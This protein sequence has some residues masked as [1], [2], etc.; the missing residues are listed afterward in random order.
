V[1]RGGGGVESSNGIPIFIHACGP[2]QT[3]NC[4]SMQ[5]RPDGHDSLGL[6]NTAGICGDGAPARNA[7]GRKNSKLSQ[8]SFM[9]AH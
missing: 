7:Q 6:A 2:T 9:S 3:V 1:F 8:K 4:P 5:V